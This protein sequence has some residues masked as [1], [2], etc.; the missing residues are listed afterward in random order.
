MLAESLPEYEMSLFGAYVPKL[1]VFPWL[2]SPAQ[3]VGG[4][5]EMLLS[6]LRYS[7]PRHPTIRDLAPQSNVRRYVSMTKKGSLQF[8][9]VYSEQ[10]RWS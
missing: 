6:K 9:L 4:D 10:A 8:D 3:S 2:H 1:E 7:D 5:R